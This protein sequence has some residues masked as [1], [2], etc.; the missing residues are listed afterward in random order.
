MLRIK[1]AMVDTG[2]RVIWSLGAISN[3]A[4]QSRL[5]GMGGLSTGEME[6]A[7]TALLCPN[8]IGFLPKLWPA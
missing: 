7:L 1:K 5:V 3:L 8:A 6:L 4:R 2:V